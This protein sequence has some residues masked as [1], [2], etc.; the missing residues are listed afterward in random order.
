MGKCDKEESGRVRELI[1]TGA[2]MLGGV[3]GR[4]QTGMTLSRK[5]KGAGRATMGSFL[6]RPWQRMGCVE[7]DVSLDVMDP[8][9][10]FPPEMQ[11]NICKTKESKS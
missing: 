7:E 1:E 6:Q 8:H 3:V 10:L 4:G 5:L 2:A 11:A 9:T